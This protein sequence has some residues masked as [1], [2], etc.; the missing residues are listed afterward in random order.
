MLQGRL[1]F[2]FQKLIFLVSFPLAAAS[3]NGGGFHAGPGI[4]PLRVSDAAQE[5]FS[6]HSSGFQTGNLHGGQGRVRK[7]GLGCAVK[8]RYQNISRNGEAHF[9]ER[10]HQMDGKEIIGAD[11]GVW[12]AAH[13]V[14]LL[15]QPVRIAIGRI[16]GGENREPVVL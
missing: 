11:K 15:D 2:F 14:Q 9:L 13:P 4:G 6:G 8:A 5:N 7:G 10:A 1:L 16:I 3:P 12:D